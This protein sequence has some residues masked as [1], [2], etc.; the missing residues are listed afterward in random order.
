MLQRDVCFRLLAAL[1]IA[2]A[3]G[4]AGAADFVPHSTQKVQQITG[5]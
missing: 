4:L 1:L 2:A 5:D 3:P